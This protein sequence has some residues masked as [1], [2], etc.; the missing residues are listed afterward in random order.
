MFAR[1]SRDVI[2]TMDAINKYLETELN[3]HPGERSASRMTTSCL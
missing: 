3:L 2:D 1:W